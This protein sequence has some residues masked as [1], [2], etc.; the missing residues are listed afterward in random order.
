M[1]LFRHTATG[2]ASPSV[3]SSV[4]ATANRSAKHQLW[5]LHSV[6]RAG[7]CPCRGEGRP[8][9]CAPTFVCEEVYR[10]CPPAG[11]RRL[12]PRRDGRRVPY[13]LAEG[14]ESLAVSGVGR[15]QATSTRWRAPRGTALTTR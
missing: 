5:A 13:P 14:G 9:P 8:G 15:E 2:T 11:G 10:T 1:P 4:A 3:A 12:L 7:S 6:C